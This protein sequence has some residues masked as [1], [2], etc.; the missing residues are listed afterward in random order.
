M[1][2][3]SIYALAALA[4]IALAWIGLNGYSNDD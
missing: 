4:F 3:F 2:V 1:M